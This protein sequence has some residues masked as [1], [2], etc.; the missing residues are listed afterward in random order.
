MYMI[1]FRNEIYTHFHHTDIQFGP[2]LE[3]VREMEV[4]VR[5]NFNSIESKTEFPLP[6]S[7]FGG[8]AAVKERESRLTT[9]N[10]KLAEEI[11]SMTAVF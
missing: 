10:G 2:I 7:Y 11:M 4:S 1:S 5:L 8:Q 3:D 6:F 9:K